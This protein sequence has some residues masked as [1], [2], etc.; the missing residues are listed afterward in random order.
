MRTS[1]WERP[2]IWAEAQ[3]GRLRQGW[4]T[5]EDQN[6]E[7]IAMMPVEGAPLSASQQEAVGEL[8]GC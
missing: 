7:L 6:L 2:Y 1:P 8:S 3:A 4:G 5:E